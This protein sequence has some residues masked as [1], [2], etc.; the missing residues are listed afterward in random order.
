MGGSQGGVQGPDLLFPPPSVCRIKIT[1]GR[2][3]FVRIVGMHGLFSQQ[4]IVLETGHNTFNVAQSP[5][6]DKNAACT[7]TQLPT[8]PHKTHS[9]TPTP[10]LLDSHG[11]TSCAGLDIS[12]C[13]SQSYRGRS[14]HN[15]PEI[16][17]QREP[18]IM[19]RRA[20]TGKIY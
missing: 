12:V 19:Q 1:A 18:K 15:P 9:H 10:T 3:F 5:G 14:K 13:V 20:E 7:H 11:G 17:W 6:S 16:R 8:H 2:F 4:D